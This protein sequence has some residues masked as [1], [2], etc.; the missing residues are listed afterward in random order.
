MN[1]EVE[2][3]KKRID[4]VLASKHKDADIAKGVIEAVTSASEVLLEIPVSR[5]EG[6]LISFPGPPA[7]NES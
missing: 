4:V 2:N 7:K 5:P 3:L 6:K 1:D